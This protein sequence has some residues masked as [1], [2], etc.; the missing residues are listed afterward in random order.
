MTVP[1]LAPNLEVLAA[2]E[3]ERWAGWMRYLFTKGITGAD[4]CF[5]IEPASVL[6]WR[7]QMETPYAALTESEKESDRV[8]VRKTLAA[9]TVPG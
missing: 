1:F 2:V 7:R 8:E 3:H 4:G 5:I 6:H 9:I